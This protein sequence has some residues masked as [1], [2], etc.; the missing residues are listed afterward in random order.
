MSERGANE[1]PVALGGRRPALE[2]TVIPGVATGVFPARGAMGEFAT[3][4]RRMLEV[5]V[6]WRDAPLEAKHFRALR[7]LTVGFE[8]GCDV[9]L[10]C[11]ATVAP[12]Y[13][14]LEPAGDGFAVS[15]TDAMAIEVQG[16]DGTV[17]D[18]RQ[19]EKEGA[20]VRGAD[21]RGRYVLPIGER[22]AVQLGPLTLLLRF[23]APAAVLARNFGRTFDHRFTKIFGFAFL[24]HA[25]VLGAFLVTPS[26]PGEPVEDLFK[27][28]NRYTQLL[29]KEAPKK[30]EPVRRLELEGAKNGGKAKDKEGKFGKADK[31]QQDAVAS[32]KGAQHVDSAASERDRRVVMN[33]GIFRVLRAQGGAVSD[34]FGPG[35]L[36]SGIQSALGGLRGAGL[37]DAGGSSG[38][39]SRGAG[40]GGGGGS[41]GV[42]GLGNGVGRGTGGL[43][44]LDLGGRGRDR[45]T[46]APAT[47]LTKGCLSGDA[48]LRVL[49]RVK[50]QAKYCYERGLQTNPNLEG[51]V[52]TRFVI[53]PGGDVQSSEVSDSTLHNVEVETCLLRVV[54]RLSFPPCT[55]GGVAEVTYP[56]IFKAGGAN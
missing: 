17:A 28:P 24:A 56:W 29:I 10:P 32:S 37:G 22:V 18:R 4:G 30:P 54:Q 45:Y 52:T 40:A 8:P 6:V 13:T 34:V 55:G 51:K 20:L 41:L 7:P 1:R 33:S 47:P 43:G 9:R 38:L 15:L 31:P 48:V 27:N 2:E 53:G 19:L 14:L 12:R 26:D 5:M 16:Q 11:A 25:F 36:G 42:G 21:G 3:K 50:S 46:I 44:N 49:G 23:V 39:G 35:G